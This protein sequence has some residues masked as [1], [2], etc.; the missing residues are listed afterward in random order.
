MSAYKGNSIYNNYFYNI[1][2]K[3]EKKLNHLDFISYDNELEKAIC[4]CKEFWNFI[5]PFLSFL[6]SFLFFRICN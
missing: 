5:F 2:N 3:S 4:S 1:K 6:D